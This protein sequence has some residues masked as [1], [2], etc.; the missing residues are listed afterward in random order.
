M[1]ALTLSILPTAAE[2]QPAYTFT[3]IYVPGSTGTVANGVND[4]GQIVGTFSDSSGG[5]GFLYSGGVYT[6]LNAP[7]TPYGINDKGQ[8]V[9]TFSDSNGGHGFLYSGGVYTTLDDPQSIFDPA[10]G[11][12]NCPGNTQAYGINNA[13]QIVGQYTDSNRLRH[14]FLYSGGS[15]TT[16]DDPLA[17]NGTFA[18]GINGTV[19]SP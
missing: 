19:H 16:L 2:A 10:C 15:Y 9:G 7:V 3:T 5:H 12:L 6:T 14:G 11:G 1:L 18:R 8:I 4:A 13:G 17:T